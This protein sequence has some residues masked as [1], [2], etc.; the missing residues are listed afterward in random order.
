[1]H[2]FLLSFCVIAS[3]TKIPSPTRP[4][5]GLKTQ[6]GSGFLDACF[7]CGNNMQRQGMSKGVP[8]ILCKTRDCCAGAK[9]EFVEAS[10]LSSLEDALN[11]LRIEEANRNPVDT[12]L[13]EDML[14]RTQREIEK[15]TQRIERLYTFLEDGTYDRDTFKTRLD[16]AQK[17]K[18]A[19][20]D[21]AAKI[22]ADIA[23]ASKQDRRILIERIENVLEQYQAQNAQ[24]RNI[25]LKSVLDY[26]EYSKPKKTSPH[27]FTITLFLR[28]FYSN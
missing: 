23:Q 26:A 18:L 11:K 6:P 8:H 24:G 14:L 13:L 16:N 21:R 3:G 10:V 15:I 25:L 19:Q 27:D 7:V 1:M 9:F 22:S 12:S 2:M 17:E 28:E 5:A 20:E 4:S